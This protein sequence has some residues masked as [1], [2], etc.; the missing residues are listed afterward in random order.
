M[1]L[2][3]NRPVVFFDLETTGTNAFT[4][5]IVEISVVKILTDGS[6]EV[7]TRRLNPQMHI[8]EEA[9]A[10]HH[11]KDEDVA[12]EPTFRQISKNFY[13]F[14]EGCD[15]AGYNIA[16]FDLPLLINE[17][18]RAGLDFSASGRRI[19]DAYTVF[20]R[21]EPRTLSAAYKHYCGKKLEG[22][23]GAEADILATIEV[24]EAQLDRYSNPDFNGFPDGIEKFPANLDELSEFCKTQSPE[25]V[26]AN[27]RFKWRGNE[28]I[29]SFGRYA[30]TT[31]R[32]V[33][34]DY[35]DF[36]RW[37]IRSDFADDVKQIAKDALIG[38]FPEKNKPS[39]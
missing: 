38:K 18:K 6:R 37:I 16:K 21:M 36:L 8:P 26:D 1:N 10:I 22:A 2:T 25:W 24:L 19:I 39:A 7:R 34:A 5:R 33:S 35:P 11:I 28:V 31:L 14:L 15:L 17:F 23:H 29:V 20:T 30:G 9:S 27:G 4:D 32:Q 3:E 13:I 12:N